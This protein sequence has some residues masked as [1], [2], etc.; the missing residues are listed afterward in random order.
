MQIVGEVAFGALLV[1]LFGGAL[2]IA[3]A[4]VTVGEAPHDGDAGLPVTVSI[5]SPTRLRLRPI[6]PP[7][8]VVFIGPS[9]RPRVDDQLVTLL[10]ERRGTHDHVTVEIASAFPFGLQWW[11]R[12]VDLE[13]GSTLCIAPRLGVAA[14]LPTHGENHRGGDFAHRSAELGQ[15]RGSRSYRPGDDRR[16]INWRSTAHAGELMVREL[17]EAEAEPVV[18]IVTLPSEDDAAERVA[19]EAMGTVLR[20][21]GRGNAVTLTTLEAT[22]PT[23]SRVVDRRAAGRRLARAISRP[24]SGD[25]RDDA[26]HDAVHD[27]NITV[28]GR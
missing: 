9:A 2:V 20:L 27:A 22:G 24:R 12:R 19:E 18:V 14:P 23:T 17:E 26:V 7:G 16:R 5:A 11:R 4:R 15:P 1:G 25:H 13:L 21:L 8:P 10:P 6:N 3:R 28:I